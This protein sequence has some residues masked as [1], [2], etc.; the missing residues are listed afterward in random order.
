MSL[1][2][3]FTVGIHSTTATTP[4][5]SRRAS[6]GADSIRSDVEARTCAIRSASGSW[7]KSATKAEV[8]I[9]ILAD[10][11][12]RRKAVTADLHHLLDQALDR[13]LLA[14]FSLKAFAK[15]FDDGLSECL[16]AAPSP[17]LG[18]HLDF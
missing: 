1:I 12:C 8:S 4:S 13:L 15:G 3:A 11:S 16:T 7:S 18:P 17:G 2:I 9:I 10:H 6:G 14:Q 5:N